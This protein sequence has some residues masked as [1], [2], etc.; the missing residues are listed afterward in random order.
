MTQP[1]PRTYANHRSTTSLAIQHQDWIDDFDH[2]KEHFDLSKSIPLMKLFDDNNAYLDNSGYLS[3]FPQEYDDPCEACIIGAMWLATDAMSDE[4][5][6]YDQMAEIEEDLAR[7]WDYPPM[8]IGPNGHHTQRT[9]AQ[10]SYRSLLIQWLRDEWA[11][12]QQEDTNGLST[13]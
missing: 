9:V 10:I 6:S 12:T 11:R 1:P 2:V 5:P 4:Y 3:I 8:T 7:L 13:T